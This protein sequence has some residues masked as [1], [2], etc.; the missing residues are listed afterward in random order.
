MRYSTKACLIAI[1]ISNTSNL[2]SG[3][4]DVDNQFNCQLA[5]LISLITS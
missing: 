3:L 1:L 4:V 2:L 5:T